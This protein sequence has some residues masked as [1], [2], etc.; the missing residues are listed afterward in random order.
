M[1]RA[2]DREDDADFFSAASE[3]GARLPEHELDEWLDAASEA[4]NVSLD[5]EVSEDE[6]RDGLG[7]LK[8]FEKPS[9]I[10]QSISIMFFVDLSRSMSRTDFTGRPELRRIDAVV[11]VLKRFIAQQQSMGAAMDLYSLVTFATSKH[12][13]RFHRLRASEA[14]AKLGSID[15]TPDGAMVYDKIVRCIRELAVPGQVCRVIFLSD[16]CPTGLQRHV[17]PSFQAV[18]A[19]N[20]HVILHCIGFGNCDFSILQQLAQIGRGSFNCADMDIDSLVNTF[21]TVSKTITETRSTVH[22]RER[23]TRQVAFDSA[24]RFSGNND[25]IKEKKAKAGMRT[26]LV[27]RGGQLMKSRSKKC[28]VYLH[29]N[30]F[31]QG[32]M[33]LVHRFRDQDL[34][35]KM[36]AKFSRYVGDDNSWDFIKGFAQS[37][38]Q[39]RKFSQKFHEAVLWRCWADSGDDWEP[40]R[41]VKCTQSFVYEVQGMLFTGEAFLEGSQR[42]FLKWINN[43]GE[44]LIPEGSSN[45]SMVPEAFAHFSLDD[46]GGQMMVADLQGVLLGSKRVHLTD[47]QILSLDQSFGA[48][49]LG[50]AAMQRFR[51]MHVCNKLCR[52]LGLSSLSSIP[53]RPRTRS[54]LNN[55]RAAPTLPATPPPSVPAAPQPERG[56]TQS[57]STVVTSSA[58][59]SEEE[60]LK[61]PDLLIAGTRAKRLLFVGEYTHLF[62]V[63]A[64]KL[65]KARLGGL[66][67]LEWWTTELRWPDSTRMQQE[68]LESKSFLEP[69][70]VQVLNKVDATQLTLR[71]LP[72]RDLAG[73]LWVMPFPRDVQAQS[74]SPEI[75]C[76]IKDLIVKFVHN[77]STLLD[78]NIDGVGGKVSLVLLAHQHLAWKLPVQL[79]TCR[80]TFLREVFWLDLIPFLTYGYRPRFGD[81]RDDRRTAR[82]HEGDHVVIVQWRRKLGEEDRP[83]GMTDARV[84]SESASARSCSRG[85]ASR[86]RS[87]SR[88][89]SHSRGHR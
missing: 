3:D 68:L 62:T 19:E 31:M 83:A 18:A 16:G 82:Y 35:T 69:L 54:A 79:E 28:I 73:A 21:T 11:T 39:T 46:S 30:P 14:I 15:F 85:S 57:R 64:A 76:A 9:A 48:A 51:S 72:A 8:A 5:S 20:P 38:I 43:R 74:S 27:L 36:V 2:A 77:V 55:V 71:R 49:D 41:M 17:L 6:A 22:R 47:P 86:G 75:A 78:P 10:D 4:S 33:R 88:R 84:R 70:G 29:D 44:I 42:G 45:Y 63:A 24:K 40:P 7:E 53:Q 65:V 13:V 80:G 81:R 37:T 34:P 1:A 50:S 87:S 66:A 23:H 12:E 58:G 52:K 67:P 89:R 60:F 32:G 56:R 61:I 59:R 25:N 26:T